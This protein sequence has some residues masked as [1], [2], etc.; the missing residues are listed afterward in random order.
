MT[1]S[2]SDPP[3]SPG[4]LGL[5]VRHH[6]QAAGLTQEELAEL[7]GISTRAVSDIER[8]LR[9]G[10][11]RD[12]AHRLAGALNLE[13]N[14]RAGLLEAARR[15]SALTAVPG[16]IP[17]APP[18]VLHG[19]EPELQAIA[20]LIEAGGRRLVTLVGPPGVGKS[21]LA[22]EAAH[23]AVRSARPCWLVPLAPISSAD[24]VPSAVLRTLELPDTG[25]SLAR[26]AQRLPAGSLLVLDNFEHVL[27]AAPW[28]A[29]LL[30]SSPTVTVL[31]TSRAPLRLLLEQQVSVEP[32]AEAPAVELFRERVSALSDRSEWTETDLE[33]A[34]R[35]C[36]RLD[37]LPLALELGAAALSHLTLASLAEGLEQHL[38][39]LGEGWR[40]MP[41]RHRSVRDAVAWSAELLRPEDRELLRALSVF[42]GSFGVDA[43]AGIA[44]IEKDGA[45]QGL[46]RLVEQ[47]LVR[48]TGELGGWPRYELLEVVRQVAREEALAA[49]ELLAYRRRHLEH[50]VSLAEDAERALHSS[51]RAEWSERLLAEVDN[52]EAALE[53]AAEGRQAD[54]GLRLATAL[55]RWWR[56]RGALNP[57]RAHF[58]RLLNLPDASAGVRARALWGASWLALH[59]QDKDESRSLNEELL[60]LAIQ[61][62]D[63]L[64]RRNALTGL[65]M[66]LRY[67]DRAGESLPLFREAV[68]LARQAGD[69][70]I[71]ATSIFNVGQ[72]LLE[73]GALAEGEE[74]LE[75]ARRRYLELGDAG[76]AARMLLYRARAAVLSAEPSRAARLVLEAAETFGGLGEQWGQVECLEVGAAVLALVGRDE[77]AAAAL[78][79]AGALHALLGSAPLGPDAKV[80]APFLDAARQRAGAAWETA[81]SA[82]AEV[83]LNEALAGVISELG[84][85]A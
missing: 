28:L 15:P 75:D 4:D 9:S 26:I 62:E 20:Q 31:T 30:A 71:L 44:A 24:A 78:G 61:T 85:I 22:L 34:Q 52:L 27:D 70:W 58:R 10:I 42:A 5:L 2:P 3:T 64:A 17:P 14:A 19:R 63:D 48:V 66:V 65:G 46:A 43:V 81:W 49:G 56:Q 36:A 57:G 21:R 11:Y 13:P 47:S 76:F 35:V 7:A 32:L 51:G 72:P 8:G 40:D 84:E 25:D 33:L 37:R 59:Q 55:W 80:V 77:A 68:E 6:R 38:D 54:L 53:F 39:V 29:E 41:A 79:T 67:E 16:S 50:F 1:H 82:G 18:T 73:I 23:Q 69:P 74:L 12:T 83:P 45:I 60:D